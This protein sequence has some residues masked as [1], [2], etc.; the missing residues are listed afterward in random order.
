MKKNELSTTTIAIALRSLRT[1]INMCIANGLIKGDTKEMFK[2]TG[3]NKAQSRKHEFLDVATMR[4]LYDFWKADEAKDKDGNELFLGREKY[5][6]FRDLGLFLL[7]IWAM[8][9]ILLIHSD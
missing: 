6:I 1:I 8:G 5:A 2:D 7:C 9:R 3:Y 4:K